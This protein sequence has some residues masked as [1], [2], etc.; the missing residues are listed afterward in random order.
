MN[1]RSIIGVRVDVFIVG[2]VVV[3]GKTTG[4]SAIWVDVRVSVAVLVVSSLL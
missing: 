3:G 4:E 2:G 1:W